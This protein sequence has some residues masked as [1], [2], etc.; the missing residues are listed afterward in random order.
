MKRGGRWVGLGMIFN[1]IGGI[2]L[3]FSRALDPGPSVWEY[4]LA[5]EMELALPSHLLLS[6]PDLAPICQSCK[7]VRPIN[8]ARLALL[9]KVSVVIFLHTKDMLNLWFLGLLEGGYSITCAIL[10]HL[11]LR[12]VLI[13]YADA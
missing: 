13:R 6:V 4:C 1:T 10:T 7:T 11:S 2:F 3:F 12:H 5:L 9:A 8:Y